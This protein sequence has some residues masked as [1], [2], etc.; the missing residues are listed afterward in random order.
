MR[1]GTRWAPVYAPDSRRS[2]PPLP[3][4]RLPPADPPTRPPFAG[5]HRRRRTQAVR[6]ASSADPADGPF[7]GQFG[8]WTITSVRCRATGSVAGWR[9]SCTAPLRRCWSSQPAAC[10]LPLLHPPTGRQAGG[11]DVSRLHQRCGRSIRG[12]HR[13][14][15]RPRRGL[16]AAAAAAGQPAGGG[17][18]R[19]HGGGG[20]PRPHLRGP[21]QA[22]AAGA[23]GRGRSRRG[24]PGVAAPGRAAAGGGGCRPGGGVAGGA[25][26]C[27]AHRHL[28]QRGAWV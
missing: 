26:L 9:R 7:P 28:L 18:R 14:G 13:G 20:R 4:G 15:A 12:R 21:A 6:A 2:P 11:V 23:A 16:G 27:R 3:P 24:V 19:G 8:E 10:L 17:G 5:P 25:R 22:A 1:E